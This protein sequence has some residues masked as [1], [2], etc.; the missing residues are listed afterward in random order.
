MEKNEKRAPKYLERVVNIRTKRNES[1]DEWS[2]A[3]IVDLIQS[4]YGP[5]QISID[6]SDEE[7]EEGPDIS[8]KATNEAESVLGENFLTPEAN[9]TRVLNFASRFQSTFFDV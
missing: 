1:G 8:A 4:F 6:L 5:N 9:R 2:L 3:A 7:I